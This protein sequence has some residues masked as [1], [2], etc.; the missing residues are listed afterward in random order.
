MAEP[1]FAD[2]PIRIRVVKDP[3]LAHAR[4]V[5]FGQRLSDVLVPSG[6]GSYEEL[7]DELLEMLTV[8]QGKADAPIESPY[9]S[10]ME[11]A[12]AY[13]ARGFEIEML[14]LAQEH[15]GEYE[16]RKFRTGPLRS[17][18]EAAR[19][20]VDLGSR[21]LTQEVLLTD[22]RRDAGEVL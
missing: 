5:Q 1:A 11:V 12:T 6:L 13:I 15:E 3:P 17:F 8:L 7:M 10:L 14:I 18:I 19:K 2:R 16:L 9:L 21:R 4:H 20:Y 22:Q